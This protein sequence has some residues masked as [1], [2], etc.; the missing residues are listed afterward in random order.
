MTDVLSSTR[1]EAKPSRIGKMARSLVPAICDVSVTNVCNATCN[2]CAYAHDKGIVT[3]RRWVDQAKFAEAMPIL[4]RRGVRYV[5]FQGGEPLLHPK[6]DMLVADVLANGMTPA[7]ITNGWLLP[8]KIESLAA[9]GLSTLLVSLDSHSVELHEKNRGLKGLCARIKEGVTAARKHGITTVSVVTVNHLVDFPQL[10]A[11]L[12]DIGFDAVSFSYP[13]KEPFGSSSLVYGSDSD[14][15]DFTPDQ[16][17]GALDAI[18]A[19][20]SEFTVMN[21]SAALEDMKRFVRGEKQ[22]IACV[23]GHKYFYLDWTLQIWRCEAWHEPLGSVFDLDNIADRRDRCTACM[24]NCY[25]DTST[26]MHAGVA[27]ADAMLSASKGKLGEA[28]GHLFQRSV[29]KSLGSVIEEAGVIR[30]LARNRVA[31]SRAIP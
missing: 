9:A 14:L 12:K 24:Q 6:I 28:A 5:N 7:L 27:V 21:P 18:K 15:V 16:L 30:R 25:R 3:D 10:P 1:A 11:L 17:I 31:S 20:K 22:L 23:G 19:L 4:H 29:A 8:Q 26:L 13:R 2:F